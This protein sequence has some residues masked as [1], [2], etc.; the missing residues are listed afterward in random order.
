M[1]RLSLPEGG[2]GERQRGAGGTLV[3]DVS[4]PAR[5]ARVLSSVRAGFRARQRPWV[6]GVRRRRWCCVMCHVHVREYRTLNTSAVTQDAGGWLA[7]V[8]WPWTLNVIS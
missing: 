4:R 3:S 5:A 6:Y 8:D 7:C 2:G 1:I